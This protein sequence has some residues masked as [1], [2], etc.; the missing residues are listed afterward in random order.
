MTWRVLGRLESRG[1]F[2]TPGHRHPA[3]GRSF[4][5]AAD[6]TVTYSALGDALSKFHGSSDFIEAMCLGPDIEDRP[7][8][9]PMLRNA[10]FY[11]L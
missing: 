7:V 11:K 3:V 8:D 1:G 6:G 9:H 2:T 5:G 10:G 4:K